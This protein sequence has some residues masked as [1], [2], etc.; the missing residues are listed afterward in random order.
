MGRVAILF[1]R[2]ESA[3]GFGRS[4]A[5]CVNSGIPEAMTI[6]LSNTE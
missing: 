6:D 4:G 1:A 5:V 3:T 2:G